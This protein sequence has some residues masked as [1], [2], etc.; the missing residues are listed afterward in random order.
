MFDCT[1][2]LLS[3]M[4]RQKLFCHTCSHINVSY[5]CSHR[6][7]TVIHAHVQMHRL[8]LHMHIF[9]QTDYSHTCSYRNIALTLTHVQT[10]QFRHFIH[11]SLLFII[12]TLIHN[13]YN[14]LLRG[15]NISNLIYFKLTGKIIM[16]I[17][18]HDDSKHHFLSLSACTNVQIPIIPFINDIRAHL[19]HWWATLKSSEGRSSLS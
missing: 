6:Q 9:T 1:H 17:Y 13:N 7:I 5:T 4:F 15:L 11:I 14:V 3:H 12:C 16:E 18:V 2:A 8:L 10:W 19:C